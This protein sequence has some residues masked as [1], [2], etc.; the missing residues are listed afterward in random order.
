M[1]VTKTIAMIVNN[2]SYTCANVVHTYLYMVSSLTSIITA[3]K[4]CGYV[5]LIASLKN[6]Y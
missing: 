4:L 1:G 5:T 3:P 6:T 2:T